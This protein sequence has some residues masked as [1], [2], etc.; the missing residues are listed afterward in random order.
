MFS[1]V[2]S[3]REAVARRSLLSTGKAW[4]LVIQVIEARDPQFPLAPGSSADA[5]F[6][7]LVGTGM[8]SLGA[9]SAAGGCSAGAGSAAGACS[10][11]AGSAGAGAGAA[12]G[13]A[14]GA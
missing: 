1:I 14:A 5:V 12:P 7:S 4:A 13:S 11:G 3:D 10:A 6:S 2:Q 9:G 8:S